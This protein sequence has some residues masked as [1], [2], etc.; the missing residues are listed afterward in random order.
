VLQTLLWPDEVRKVRFGSLHNS[1]PPGD[2]QLRAA[3]ALASALSGDFDPSDY[4]DEYQ[5]EL[6]RLLEDAI[7]RKAPAAEP[8]SAKAGD[9]EVDDLIATLRRSLNT[10]TAEP[11]KDT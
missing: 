5:T 9:A 2:P 7:A 10:A 4:T 1:D 6:K 8:G 3:Q 11:H